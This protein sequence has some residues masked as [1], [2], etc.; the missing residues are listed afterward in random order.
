VA[1]LGWA[2]ERRVCQA[3]RLELPDGQTTLVSNLHATGF[4]DER[5]ADAELLR[6]AVF[7]HGLARP[8]ELCFLAGDFNVR[9]GRSRTL[10]ELTKPE[11]GF[12]EP[13]E[14][15]DQILVRGADGRVERWPA[16]RRRVD[17]RLLSD[18][19][20]VEVRVE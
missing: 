2:K 15:I 1:R 9:P 4:P 19:A 13:T 17:G 12:S 6:A 16:D 11:W 20:P 3:V 18:H 7:A 14:G 8:D 5:L 10:A